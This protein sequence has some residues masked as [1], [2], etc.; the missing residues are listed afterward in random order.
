MWITLVKPL[1]FTASSE[2][3]LAAV[4]LADASARRVLQPE[5]Q[6]R[7]DQLRRRLRPRRRR[8][9]RRLLRHP[10]RRQDLLPRLMQEA[11]PDHGEKGQGWE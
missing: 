8:R 5:G 6:P 9:L 10:R 2:R 1:L 11:L 4:D 3:A 7:P